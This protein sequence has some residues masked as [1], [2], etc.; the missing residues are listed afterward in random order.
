M[1]RT[2]EETVAFHMGDPTGNGGDYEC[3]LLENFP[4]PGS[5]V[6]TLPANLTSFLC[7][8]YR[9]QRKY[10]YNAFSPEQVRHCPSEDSNRDEDYLYTKESLPKVVF[11]AKVLS[12]GQMIG[13]LAFTSD[14]CRVEVTGTLSTAGPRG[15]LSNVMQV[16]HD[17]CPGHCRV[18]SAANLCM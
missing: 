15:Y 10:K 1:G 8:Y 12:G 17:Q 2:L 6:T 4:R 18:N 3:V 16:T 14:P 9:F 5:P 11:P 13:R 7:C